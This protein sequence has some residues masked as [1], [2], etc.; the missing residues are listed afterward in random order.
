MDSIPL[1]LLIANKADKGALPEVAGAMMVV[2]CT[3]ARAM[4][5]ARQAAIDARQ[6]H[7][8]LLHLSASYARD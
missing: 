3:R 8:G 6:R 2:N 7:V 5:E 4:D 1:G